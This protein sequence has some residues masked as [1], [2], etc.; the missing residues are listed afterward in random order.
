MTARM[1][2]IRHGDEP[3]DD[4]VHAFATSQGFEPAVI[5]PFTGEPLGEPDDAVHGAVVYGGRFEAY[6]TG[7]YPF[8]KDEA[9]WIEA[10]MKRNIP[11]L[12]ICQG[13]QQIAHVLGAPVGPPPG[14]QHEFGY[15]PVHATEA[16][17]P[18][19]PASIHVAQSHFHTFGIPHGAERLA[20]SDL[21]DNQAFRYGDNTYAFQFHAEVAPQGFRRWQERPGAP[22][23]ELGAQPRAEQDRL[24][25]VHDAVQAEWF[26][27]F[28]GRL[29]GSALSF[30]QRS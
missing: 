7:K 23:G 22:Y 18:I 27:G 11:L 12:G 25:L 29:F 24:M 14:G 10:C 17:K 26:F 4:R 5:R 16:G 9:R 20:S 3:L 1:V 2:L 28:L 13:A 21:F 30:S 8:L 6:E 15:Y 19:L